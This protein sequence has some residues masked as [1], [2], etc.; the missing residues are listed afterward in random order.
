MSQKKSPIIRVES[1]RLRK[2][3]AAWRIFLMP[4]IGASTTVFYSI[5]FGVSLLNV[6]V[7][8]GMY[9]LV[10]IGLE[11]GFHRLFAHRAFSTTKTI[12]LILWGFGMM[13]AQAKG[14]YWISTHLSHHSNSDTHDD[15]HSPLRRT[16]VGGEKEE[17][18]LLAGLWH[19]HQG[20]TMTAYPTNVSRYASRFISD[21][22]FRDMDA[23]FPYWVALGVV[24]PGLIGLI[25]GGW[26][27]G[28]ACALWGGPMRIFAQHH[29]F[30]T[31]GSLAHR[32]GEQVFNTKDNSRNNWYCS[33]WTFGS[34][35][36]N[37]H[38]AFANSAY[39]K[40][41]WYESDIAGSVIKFLSFLG[42]AWNV[43][44]INKTSAEAIVLPGKSELIDKL[45]EVDQ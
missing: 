21:P 5:V 11:V 15:P 2:V 42:L 13:A 6:V 19:A 31:N 4:I 17:L 29:A 24:I 34:A 10:T 43:K 30:F 40:L 41:R 27:E 16:T 14:I 23:K 7:F 12:E 26:Q 33:Y 9:I 1:L 38:H 45:P 18:S 22:F 28:I 35:L 25:F 36:Q 20:N 39:L 44:G 3:K 32:F 8:V 37:T